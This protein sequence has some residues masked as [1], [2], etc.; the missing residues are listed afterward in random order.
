MAESFEVEKNWNWGWI[1]PP[2]SDEINGGG[3][4]GI[5]R[6]ETGP[7]SFQWAYS[8]LTKDQYDGRLYHQSIA[9]QE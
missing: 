4:N 5:H 1:S 7:E 8:A 2:V 3:E 9:K 6:G